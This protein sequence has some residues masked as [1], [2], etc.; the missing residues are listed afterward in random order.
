MSYSKFCMSIWKKNTEPG[1]ILMFLSG[2]MRTHTW[3]MTVH[4]AE[5]SSVVGKGLLVG[6]MFMVYV[7]QHKLMASGRFTY[8]NVTQYNICSKILRNKVIELTVNSLISS[9]WEKEHENIMFIIVNIMNIN[10]RK[11]NKL[12]RINNVFY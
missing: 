4:N 9:T 12:L 1:H 6:L 5:H 11:R 3:R 7:Q 10:V 2:Q 8:E